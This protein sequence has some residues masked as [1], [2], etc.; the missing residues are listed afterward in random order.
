VNRIWH[1]R[2]TWRFGGN[3]Q[4]SGRPALRQP[5]FTLRCKLIY[6]CTF[7]SYCPIWVQNRCKRSAHDT[8]DHLQFSR[9]SNR[10]RPSICHGQNEI[11]LKRVPW[12][13]DTFEVKN[14]LVK[15][16]YY[17]TDYSICSATDFL[18]MHN[19]RRPRISAETGKCPGLHVLCPV[20]WQ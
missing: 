12:R 1:A 16:V 19:F 20:S 4:G 13:H 7:H 14:A 11:T 8:A 17:V 6:I 15:S 9:K 3:L 10:R 18:E 5:H 2:C